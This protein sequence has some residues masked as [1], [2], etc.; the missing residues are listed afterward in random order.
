V[1]IGDAFNFDLTPAKRADHFAL[2]FE[3]TIKLDK[4]G[5]YLYLIGSDDGSR[6][7]IDDK[8]VVAADGVHSFEQKRKKLKMTAG[9]HAVTVDYFE[10]SGEEVLQVDFEGPG[11][12]QRPLATL[13]T[14]R[15]RQRGRPAAGSFAIDPRGGARK[16]TSRRWAACYPR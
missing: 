4:D 2:R 10:H 1:A 3:G 9:L 11:E 12:T 6:L 14:T 5:D 15:R 7:L 13:L 16:N 8:V